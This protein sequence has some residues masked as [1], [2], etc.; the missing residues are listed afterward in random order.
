ARGRRAVVAIVFTFALSAAVSVGLSIWA[1]S[2][3]QHKA[4]V[5]EVAA[6]QR[7]LAERYLVDVLLAQDGRQ[8]DAAHTAWL[9]KKSAKALL[10]GGEAPSVPGDD[11][12]TRL[13]PATGA[14][15]RGQLV[16]ERRLVE[17]LTR[18]GTAF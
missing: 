6:R 16:Q 1:T 3:S 12:D 8:A 17:D 9:L 4:T 14:T 5:V 13:A 10:D 15:V 11:D 18:T 2:R 7:T